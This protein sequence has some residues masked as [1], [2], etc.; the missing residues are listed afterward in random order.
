MDTAARSWLADGI[1]FHGAVIH[2]GP[3]DPCRMH[4]SGA[5]SRVLVSWWC[6][7][8][9]GSFGVVQ[10][11]LASLQLRWRRILFANGCVCCEPLTFSLGTRKWV[12]EAPTTF[13]ILF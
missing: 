4:R 5:G 7:A 8:I 3:T 12:A 1:S 13:E 2:A 10:M 6:Y 11:L 9:C